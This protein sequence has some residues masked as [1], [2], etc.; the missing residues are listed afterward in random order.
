MIPD[1]STLWVIAFVLLLSVILDRLLLRPITQV[2]H[3]REGA[4]KS[5]RDL[6]ESSRA[7]AQAAS[8]E[9]DSRTRAA[10]A[11]VYKQMEDKR[12]A[13]L[14]RRAEIVSATRAEVEQT[15]SAA[16]DRIKKQSETA[17]AQIDRDADALASTIVERV[18]GRKAS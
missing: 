1:L 18:L 2:M 15:T 9:F 8:D 12:R 13:A 4:I 10:R 5:A 17:R 7:K 14:D 6:A 16:T 11:E 3:Q